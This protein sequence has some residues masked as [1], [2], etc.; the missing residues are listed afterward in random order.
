MVISCAAR[1]PCQDTIE[2]AHQRLGVANPLVHCLTNP[3]T[4][5]FVANTLLAIGASPVM[6]DHPDEAGDLARQADAVLINLGTP[7]DSRLEAMRR[8]TKAAREAERP[9]V[10]DPIGAGGLPR[11]RELALSLM[12]QHPSVIRGNASEIL[13]LAQQHGSGHG[14]DSAHTPREAHQAAQELLSWA[15]G[16]AISGASDQLF[17]VAEQNGRPRP[18]CMTLEGGS[19]WQPRVTGTGCAL[20]AMIAAY[21]A[22]CTDVPTAMLAAHLHAAAAAERAEE[23]ANGPGSFA[24]AWLDALTS[25][26]PVRLLEKRVNTH[27][28]QSSGRH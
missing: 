28:L 19:H 26:E 24:A 7:S 8:A 21:T 23:L 20:G 12:Q 1:L 17:G 15:G 3:V 4:I 27:W 9:W 22:V 10:L 6:A 13:G 11:R 2:T 18:L 25:V 5:N 16:V 14:V